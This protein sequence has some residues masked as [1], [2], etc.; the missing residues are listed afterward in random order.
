MFKKLD[1]KRLNYAE[2]D[3]LDAHDI[4]RDQM[5]SFYQTFDFFDLIKAWPDLVGPKLATVTSP[6][7]IGNGTLFVI[8]AHAAFSDTLSYTT[9]MILEKIFIQ[10][11]NL[12][13]VIKGISYQTQEGFFKQRVEQQATQSQAPKLHPQS[14]KY[15]LLKLEA[16][17]LFQD[18]E[19]Q[20]VKASLISIY[21]QSK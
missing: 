9:P 3:K 17:K 5:Q 14:P 21:I 13:K 8:S 12:K 10:F 16:E 2:L 4:K 19:D 6:L 18:V 15:K 20:E 11:P 7:K 1:F